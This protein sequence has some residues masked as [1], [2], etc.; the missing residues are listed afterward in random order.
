MGRFIN[1]NITPLPWSW[2]L[3]AWTDECLDLLSSLARCSNCTYAVE[4]YEFGIILNL[5]SLEIG[6]IDGDGVKV[7]EH[8]THFPLNDAELSEG[9]KETRGRVFRR[10]CIFSRVPVN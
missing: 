10:D 8:I 9:G 4:R 1:P 3:G 5:E 6:R 2:N 7:A